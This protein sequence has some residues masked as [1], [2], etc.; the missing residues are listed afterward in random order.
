MIELL[1]FTFVAYG[2]TTILVYGSIFNGVRD[3]IHQ[4][5]Q[6]EN[7]FILTR[8]IFKFLSGLI[9]C[10][11]CTSTWVGFF[12]SLTLFSPINYF[13]GL[14]SFYYVFFDGM[15]AAGIVWALNAIIE[16]FEENRLNNQKQTVEYI[17][18]DE[19]ESEQQK[20]ILND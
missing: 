19:D 7:G 6:D 10:P 20:E 5:A 1:L 18:P 13:I 8:P 4:Q 3:F 12:L 16:W 17:L 2:M 15:F 11:L 9:V 14:N